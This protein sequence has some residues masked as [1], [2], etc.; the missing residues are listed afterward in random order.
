MVG[1][2]G[3]SEP[4]NFEFKRVQSINIC[5]GVTKD[6]KPMPSSRNGFSAVLFEKEIYLMGGRDDKWLLLSLVEK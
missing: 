4:G 3:M 2:M 5:T 6:L 1:T